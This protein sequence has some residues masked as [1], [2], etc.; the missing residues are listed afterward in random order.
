M[1]L[2]EIQNLSFRYPSLSHF[3]L[4]PT[5]LSIHKGDLVGLL[6]PNGAGKSTLLKLMVGLV[7]PQQG[8]V[9]FEGR[10]LKDLPM[11]ERAR[12]IAYVPQGL[13]FT[14]PLSVLEIVEMGRH[15]YVGRLKPLGTKDKSVCER[16]LA[17]CDALEFKDRSYDE[18]SGGER[19]RVLLASALAQTPQVLLLDEPTLS[20]DLS[21]QILL[22]EIIRKLHREE[23]LTVVVATHELNLAG[24][25]LD[26]LVLMK[27]GK[28]FADG[29]P[30]K[31]LTP[32]NIQSV[33]NVEVD[34]LSHKGDFPYFVP[35]NKIA[36]IAR[37]ARRIGGRS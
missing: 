7:K 30:K 5:D 2:F 17:L 26:R 24:R 18:L 21:H 27:E 3:E 28:V 12:K 33:L 10:P 1:F 37:N 4:H 32:R 6:G 15:P 35:K 13:H 29:K 8:L 14:F 23:G 19:Q 22:F 9:V 25:F 20:L 34:Q 31:V 36:V 11:R 16:A